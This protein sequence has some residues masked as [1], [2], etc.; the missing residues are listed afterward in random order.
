MNK[1]IC[2]K[3]ICMKQVLFLAFTLLIFNGNRL[4]AQT[5]TTISDQTLI[6]ENIYTD[7]LKSIETELSKIDKNIFANNFLLQEFQLEIDSLGE[8]ETKRR[9]EITQRITQLEQS[10]V[11]LNEKRLEL[12]TEIKSLA[13]PIPVILFEDTLFYYYL[14]TGPS[15]AELRAKNTADNLQK[16]Y[17][18]RSF[19]SS[20]LVINETELNLIVVTYDFAILFVVTK[21]D[22]LILNKTP[23]EL[24]TI[25]R[26]AIIT[27]MYDRLEATSLRNILSNIVQVMGLA[28]LILFIIWILNKGVKP[29]KNW[30]LKNRKKYIRPL[31]YRNTEII[32]ELK[33]LELVYALINGIKWVLVAIILYTGSFFIFSLLPDTRDISQKLIS[34]IIV[35]VQNVYNGVVNFLPKLITIIVIYTAFRILINFIKYLSVQIEH[36]KLVIGNFPEDWARPTFSIVRFLI[37]ALMFIIIFPL[38]PGSNSPAFQGV[39][40]FLG[41]LISLGSTSTI[42]NIISG[43]VITYMRPFKIN[44]RV[45]AGDVTGVVI[46]KNLLVTRIR[47]AKNEEITIPNSNLITGH[48]LNYSSACENE[49]LIIHSTVTI[50]YD[51]PW[52]KMHEALIDA[53]LQVPAIEKEPA[54]FVY[55]KSLDD[56]YVSYEVNAYVRDVSHIFK[57]YS[58]MHQSIQDVCNERGIEIMSPH[59]RNLRDGN[60]STIP[61]ENLDKDY[62]AP[63]FH[64]RIDNYQT[65]ETQFIRE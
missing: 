64:M 60:M 1:Y 38:L 2:L 29:V 45:K 12:L 22:A 26:N 5:D 20:L 13:K 44:Q 6:Q 9:R 10:T 34:W 17:E 57:T 59:Y 8:V 54:P 30:I 33:M 18:T 16:I 25:E 42:S 3:L 50:G 63:P 53:V 58:Q 11:S 19:D 55:Q 36:K 61:V 23:L 65:P 40:V 48:I 51:V 28:S 4:S 62:K 56:F 47:S 21:N 7:K 31:R 14:S 27:A 15:S 52:R 24:A 39:S 37:Y 43:I 49:G 46:S 41:L 35:P 32:D